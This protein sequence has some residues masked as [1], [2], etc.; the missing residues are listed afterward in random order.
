[1]IKITIPKWLVI[2]NKK[3]NYLLYQVLL[4]YPRFPEATYPE[5]ICKGVQLLAVLL[6]E[7]LKKNVDPP[8]TT[9]KKALTPPEVGKIKKIIF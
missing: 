1:M 8:L 3:F 9:S 5:E 6:V 7:K 4:L 2:Q